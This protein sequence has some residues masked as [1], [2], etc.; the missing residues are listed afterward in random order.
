MEKDRDPFFEC[1]DANY[2][3]DHHIISL[4][5]GFQQRVTDEDADRAPELSRRYVDNLL[6]AALA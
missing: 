6:Y 3:R 4:L 5:T 1:N 2:L